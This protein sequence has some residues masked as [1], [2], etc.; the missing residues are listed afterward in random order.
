M[1][2]RDAV[3][4]VLRFEIPGDFVECGVWRGGSMMAVARTLTA[5]GAANRHLHLFDTFEGMSEPT[6]ADVDFHGSSASALLNSA[7]K[8]SS[9]WVYSPLED[10]ERNIKLTNYPSNLVHFVKGKVEDTIP[11]NAP[12][13]IALLRLDTDFYESTYHELVHLF[14]RLSPGG[15][16]IIDDYG[17]WQGARQAVDQY[18]SE[19]MLRPFLHRV[20]YTARVVVKSGR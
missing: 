15:V 8:S 2:L 13:Q 11:A 6:N 20:D 18:F 17:H 14:P 19:N 5:R 10:V 4:Y 1:A 16:L 3:D 7:E 12:D 9:I